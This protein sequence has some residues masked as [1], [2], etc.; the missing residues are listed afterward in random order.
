MS[1]KKNLHKAKKRAL[2]L[3]TV[4]IGTMLIN[5]MMLAVTKVTS[6]VNDVIEKTRQGRRRDRSSSRSRSRS[7]S[8]RPKWGGF[9][10][11]YHHRFY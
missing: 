11:H 9:H 6:R 3:A 7:E 2:D 1:Q 8:P 4:T 5:F 10:K